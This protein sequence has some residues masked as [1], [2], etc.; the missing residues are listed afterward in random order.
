MPFCNVKDDVAKI[1]TFLKE[2]KDIVSDPKEFNELLKSCV[3]MEAAS[4]IG[5]W[6]VIMGFYLARS[7]KDA[8]CKLCKSADEEVDPTQPL[9]VQEHLNKVR[10]E[11][12]A[13]RTGIT[14]QEKAE[15]CLWLQYVNN[16]SNACP[17]L[18]QPK[19]QPEPCDT[20]TF[21]NM[22]NGTMWRG[23]AYPC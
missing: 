4:F 17:S 7:M 1:K 21:K 19:K 9:Q 16:L 10:M 2:N 5:F 12:Y 6:N 20:N 13:E 18:C 11:P 3:Y 14:K 22:I 15:L 23:A 8:M